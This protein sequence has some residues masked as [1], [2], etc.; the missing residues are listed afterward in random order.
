MSSGQLEGGPSN[1]VP[2]VTLTC[3]TTTIS[4]CSLCLATEQSQP[5]SS[6]PR[7]NTDNQNFKLVK[8]SWGT[9]MLL[10]LSQTDDYWGWHHCLNQDFC[11]HTLKSTLTT[12]NWSTHSH[13]ILGMANLYGHVSQTW[14]RF[15]R[16]ISCLSYGKLLSLTVGR[17]LLLRVELLWANY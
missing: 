4:N 14:K 9:K 1:Y 12:W 6:Q 3:F 13:W 15:I 16:Q 10:T 7:Y 11:L 5:T 8:T 17:N 2:L